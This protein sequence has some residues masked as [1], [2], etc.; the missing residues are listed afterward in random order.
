MPSSTVTTQPVAGGVGDH[1][2]V[3]RLDA[4]ARPTR[5]TRTPSARA[6]L[7]RRLGRGE[8][9]A[10]GEDADLG[11][12]PVR[13][14]R[15]RAQPAADL[16]VADL[17]AAL[18]GQRMADRARRRARARRAASPAAPGADDGANTVMPGTLVSSAMSST[19]WCDG[20][21][22]AGDAGAVEAEDDRLAVEADVVDRP[23]RTPG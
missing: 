10:D 16:V 20:A 1:R 6:A 3:E 7:G 23:G 19:P 12:S 14:V 9:L 15:G 8:Q 22:V 2:R 18:F 21:V 11:P 4:P 13:T 17:R 5:C